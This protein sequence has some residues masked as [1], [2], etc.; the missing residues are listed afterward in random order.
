MRKSFLCTVL[1]LLSVTF[2]SAQFAAAQSAPAPVASRIALPAP[3][4]TG[5]MTL[6]DVLSHRRSTRDFQTTKLT[7]PELSQLL[8]AAQG[9]TDKQGHRTA[10]SAHAG[11]FLHIYV[12]D[13]DG[14][15][16]YIPAAN[17]LQ[18]LSDKDIRATLSPQPSVKAAPVVFM[19]AGEYERAASLGGV[20]TGQ[21]LVNLEAGHATE[22]LLLEAT[23]IK[24][25]GVS[26]GG[27]D[28]KLV[29]KAASLPAGISPI[30]LVPCGHAK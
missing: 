12:A 24:L 30:Y 19:V 23:A 25:T 2:V 5:G 6:N 22:N 26:V 29:A 3:A 13:A 7:M 14:F 27:I 20:E 16:E 28:P 21:R 11:Y 9:I 4:T 17:A 18:K 10:P 1:V 8:W 15:F